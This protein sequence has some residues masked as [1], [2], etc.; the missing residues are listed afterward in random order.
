MLFGNTTA[1]DDAAPLL[2]ELGLDETALTPHLAALKAAGSRYLKDL[3]LNL[4]TALNAESLGK[5]DALLIAFAVAVNEKN[6]ALQQS[7]E[8]QALEQGATVAEIAEVLACT[9][10]MNA[11][12]VYYRFRHFMN[13]E[14]YEKA[15]AGIR[16]S[17]MANPVVGKEMFEL[18]SLVVSAVNGCSLCVTSHEAALVKQGSEKQRVHDAVRVGAVV[19]SLGVVLN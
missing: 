15:P 8:K 11:N 7:F 14:F 4:S 5:K 13:D 17:I 18:I 3:K 16:M 6:T 9:S 2:K 12:N 10:L 1:Q 19:K